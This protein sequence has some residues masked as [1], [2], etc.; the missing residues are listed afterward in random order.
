MVQTVL[1]IKKPRNI[2]RLFCFQLPVYCMRIRHILITYSYAA[3]AKLQL[4]PIQFLFPR[5]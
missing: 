3:N 2:S 1:L 4:Y 5:Y